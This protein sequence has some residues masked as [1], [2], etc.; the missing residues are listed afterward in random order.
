MGWEPICNKTP[1]LLYYLYPLDAASSDVAFS[2]TSPDD[3]SSRTL[4]ESGSEVSSDVEN[5]VGLA[6]ITEESAGL[7]TNY[8]FTPS[9]TPVLVSGDEEKEIAR[10]MAEF[11]RGL[12]N[13]LKDTRL[14]DS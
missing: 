4:F 11:R 14:A 10:S 1:D 7:E 9:T 6:E 12:E 8:P 13:A 3:T 2:D 5:V